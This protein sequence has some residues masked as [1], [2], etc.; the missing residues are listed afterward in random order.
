MDQIYPDRRRFLLLVSVFFGATVRETETAVAQTGEISDISDVSYGSGFYGG[1]P[2]SGNNDGTSSLSGIAAEYD[3][4][5]DG[6]ITRQELADA[7]QDYSNGEI[8]RQNL[9]AVAMAYSNR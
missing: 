1:S 6:I 4:D 9:A 5:G 3:T 7:A 8:S 2:S